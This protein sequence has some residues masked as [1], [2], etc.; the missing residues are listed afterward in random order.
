MPHVLL[1]GLV[2]ATGLGVGLGLAEAPVT[3]PASPPRVSATS[4]PILLLGDGIGPA[5]FGQ[6][7]S[8]AVSNLH[9]VLGSPS[10][11]LMDEAGNCTIDA[12]MQWPTITAYFDHDHFVGYSTPSAT[13]GVL[14]TADMTTT[15]GLR[16]GDTLAEAQRIYGTALRTSLAQGGSWFA[17]TPDGTLDGYLTA[18]VNQKTPTPR[19]ASIEVGGVGCPGASP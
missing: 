13:G 2:L 10:S 11:G 9:K 1:G 19:I 12:A 15:K 5:R 7:E 17:T 8:S 3:K 6:A 18:E 4:G 14:Q 16:V